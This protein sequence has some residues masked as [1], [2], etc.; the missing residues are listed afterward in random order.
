MD[1]ALDQSHTGKEAMRE[2]FAGLERDFSSDYRF[3]PGYAVVTDSGYALE[4]V[5]RGTHD[6]S[7][8]MLPATGKSLAIRG[9]SVG[10]MRDG[11]IVRNTDYWN[12]T[13]FLTQVGV[14]PPAA[15][16]TPA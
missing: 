8:P 14:M 3:D 1:V 11:K 7:G 12:M 13:E 4:W 10:E 2:F 15:A 16:A 5:M 9:V 6:R